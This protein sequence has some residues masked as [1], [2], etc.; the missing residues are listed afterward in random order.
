MVVVVAVAAVA[1]ALAVDA[2]VHKAVQVIS[3]RR[4]LSWYLAD[5]LDASWC[6]LLHLS[7]PLY[8]TYNRRS[9]DNTLRAQ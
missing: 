3:G 1:G 7:L 5:W 9:V 4:G 2:V 6:S 8:I